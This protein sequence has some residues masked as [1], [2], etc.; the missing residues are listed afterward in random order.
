MGWRNAGAEYSMIDTNRKM[1][2]AR[3]HSARTAALLLG[4]AMLATAACGVGGPNP[5]P[6]VRLAGSVTPGSTATAAYPGRT[7]RCCSNEPAYCKALASPA[8]LTTL[9]LR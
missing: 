9:R 6:R 2:D 5:T 8:P 7:P 4:G 1:P 3:N